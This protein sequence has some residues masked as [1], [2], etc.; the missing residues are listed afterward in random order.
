M[1]RAETTRPRSDVEVPPAVTSH[2]GHYEEDKWLSPLRK[3]VQGKRTQDKLNWVNS[4][5]SYQKVEVLETGTTDPKKI[6]KVNFKFSYIFIS[7]CFV[8]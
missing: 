2:A 5:N 4:P 8:F 1:L 7:N 6:T 3:L